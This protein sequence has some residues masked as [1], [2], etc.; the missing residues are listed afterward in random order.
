MSKE[1]ITFYNLFWEVDVPSMQFKALVAVAHVA[2]VGL[3]VAHGVTREGSAVA[4]AARVEDVY[5][6]QAYAFA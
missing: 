4:G 6:R 1:E 5:K 2:A 3:A